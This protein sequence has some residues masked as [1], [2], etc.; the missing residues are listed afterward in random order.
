MDIEQLAAS[1]V[2]ESL[3]RT[4]RLSPFINKNDKEPSWDGHVYIHKNKNKRK[5]E[6]IGRVP[7]Q[8]KGCSTIAN[9]KLSKIHY[10]IDRADLENYLHD[11]G[12]VYFV[13]GISKDGVQKK[14]YYASLL[15]VNL[16]QIL[17][18]S[19]ASKSLDFIEFP[20]ENDA[21]TR[22]FLNF[23][24]NMKMQTSFA[25]TKILSIG[26][27]EPGVHAITTNMYVED[28]AQ[29]NPIDL[30]FD[31]SLS[32]YAQYNGDPI[33]RPILP[34]SEGYV[35]EIINE[36]ITVYNKTYYNQFQRIHSKIDTTLRIGNS[37]QLVFPKN[38][39]GTINIKYE[40]SPFLA[41]V[42]VDLDFWLS[43]LETGQFE[44]NGVP[45]PVQLS[46]D[47][48]EK[49][50]VPE[51]QQKLNSLKRVE[52]LFELLGLDKQV[53]LLTLDSQSWFHINILF[54]A[55]LDKKMVPDLN[56][57]IPILNV[58]EIGKQKV[59]L[60]FKKTDIPGSYII[61]DFFK[62]L[63]GVKIELEGENYYVPQYSILTTKN[64]LELANLDSDAIIK[65]YIEMEGNPGLY[66]LANLTI[67]K[68]L[69]AYDN[70]NDQ[71]K[72]F[73]T[74]SEKLAE[75][76]GNLSEE[77]T[78]LPR[79]L[80]VLNR[81]QIIKRK[82][83]LTKSEKQIIWQLLEQADQPYIKVGAC[84]LLDNQEAA[85]MY[86]DRLSPEKQ[87]DFRASPIFRFWNHFE[88]E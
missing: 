56:E 33:P 47:K 59:L 57:D 2:I 69:S 38:K 70:S 66:L 45:V 83:E 67:L 82:R 53:D 49:F 26:E 39:S 52:K 27:L 29:V 36:N 15:P 11:G 54:E 8:V 44:I 50:N 5:D 78:D 24:E 23:F 19:K 73:L 4:D 31:D 25:K 1:A 75:W 43:A 14:I 22:L 37:T 42:V 84:L 28:S 40:E 64:Y 30:V 32:W 77:E 68:F 65:S 16:Q 34:L 85:E 21:K 18:N 72:D 88:K 48:L 76:L 55:L 81:L 10:P 87:D 35:T 6:I 62:E 46:K 71:R 86:F 60:V 13:V 80:C 74:A 20:T 79:E 51:K 41:D 7:V 9:L 61:S 3:A 17:E 12:A 63:L 58:V